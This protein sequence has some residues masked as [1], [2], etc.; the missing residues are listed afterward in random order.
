MYLCFELL[1]N[2]VN[3]RNEGTRPTENILPL[4]VVNRIGWAEKAALAGW[5]V[6]ERAGGGLACDGSPWRRYLLR[7]TAFASGRCLLASLGRTDWP[8]QPNAR[9]LDFKTGPPLACPSASLLLS[10]PSPPKIQTIL[11][12]I[13][14]RLAA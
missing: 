9:Q 3:H 11:G 13:F 4:D 5:A 2:L 8:C 6:T 10:S 12:R 14:C 1:P 7:Q